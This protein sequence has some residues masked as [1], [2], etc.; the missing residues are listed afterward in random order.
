MTL[1]F[2]A[3][4]KFTMKFMMMSR[5]RCPKTSN[6]IKKLLLLLRNALLF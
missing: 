2:F 6:E 5:Q 1:N 4:I 3:K